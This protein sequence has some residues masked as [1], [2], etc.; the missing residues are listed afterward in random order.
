MRSFGTLRN[1]NPTRGRLR[2]WICAS[3]MLVAG[4]AVAGLGS[5]TA[6]ASADEADKHP[7]FQGLYQD[8]SLRIVVDGDERPSAE[9]WRRGN[10]LLIRSKAMDKPLIVHGRGRSKKVESI[11]FSDVQYEKDGAAWLKHDF[12]A[13]TCCVPERKKDASGQPVISFVFEGKKV[14]IVENPFM[15]GL[16]DLE[17]LLEHSPQYGRTKGSWKLDEAA[18]AELKKL[19]PL[20]L[21]VYFGSWCGRCATL[22]PRFVALERALGK[23]LEV[24]YVGLKDKFGKK[25][26]WELQADADKAHDMPTVLVRRDDKPLGRL[27]Y[28]Q[29]LKDGPAIQLLQL[30]NGGA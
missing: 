1:L 17:K 15:L 8:G 13:E 12:K 9:I 30:L 3:A 6:G 22:M 4:L 19:K 26:K 5:G 28:K 11:R 21:R 7:D 2:A 14:E 24:E 27:D 23:V 18:V 20:T 29:L 16:V 10:T 25:G